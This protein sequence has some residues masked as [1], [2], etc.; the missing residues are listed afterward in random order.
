MDVSAGDQETG[1]HG[2]RGKS[3]P[4]WSDWSI[5]GVECDNRRPLT[6][7]RSRSWCLVSSVDPKMGALVRSTLYLLRSTSPQATRL[8][9]CA[10]PPSLLLVPTHRRYSQSPLGP[11]GAITHFI[12]HQPTIS[13]K[14]SL[15]LLLRRS[16]RNLHQGTPECF[17]HPTQ[18]QSGKTPLSCSR[19]CRL[20]KTASCF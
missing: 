11:S 16:V 18:S 15:L 5:E 3:L 12:L 1:Q 2:Q 7:P 19:R 9:R 13:E 6:L 14:C 4:V 20:D 17:S 8:A 10:R